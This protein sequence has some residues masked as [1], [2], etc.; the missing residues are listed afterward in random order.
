M[1]GTRQ[2][3][4]LP[5]K[6]NSIRACIFP[7]SIWPESLWN[8]LKIPHT[9]HQMPISPHTNMQTPIPMSQTRNYN[10]SGA[11]AGALLLTGSDGN[12][13]VKLENRHKR[14]HDAVADLVTTTATTRHIRETKPTGYKWCCPTVFDGCNELP[15]RI[16]SAKCATLAV[17]KTLYD[18]E[19][20]L[21]CLLAK[22]ET[23]VRHDVFGITIAK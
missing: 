14:R 20:V 11:Q 23:Y 10:L 18:C 21:L 2:T 15:F 6:R 8:T 4:R 13:E 12:P 16:L 3:Q 19:H 9:T 17:L 5:N 1:Q 7:N 22:F